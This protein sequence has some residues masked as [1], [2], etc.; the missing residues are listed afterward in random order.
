MEFFFLFFFCSLLLPVSAW[1]SYNAS[2]HAL[3]TSR[4]CP[5]RCAAWL[6]FSRRREAEKAFSGTARR[7]LKSEIA[8]PSAGA[9]APPQ[10]DPPDHQGIPWS[11][12]IVSPSL[13]WSF[14]YTKTFWFHE[15]ANFWIGRGRFWFHWGTCSV[16]RADTSSVKTMTTTATQIATGNIWWYYKF[17][18]YPFA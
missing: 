5:S 3:C 7:R 9:A 10:A 11:P 8:G 16:D 4:P 17:S 2:A 6:R 13:A 15:N 1:L 14:I 12:R 18:V